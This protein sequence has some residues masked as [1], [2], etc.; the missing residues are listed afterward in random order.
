MSDALDALD[1]YCESPTVYGGMQAENERLKTCLALAR[2]VGDHWR[3]NWSDFD[4]CTLRHQMEDLRR[5]ADG[6]LSGA[7]YRAQWGLHA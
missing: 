6:S 2:E 4:R 5:V 1:R 3:M 7:G